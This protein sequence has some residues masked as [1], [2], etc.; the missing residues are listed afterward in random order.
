M[1]RLAAHLNFSHARDPDDV[2]QVVYSVH[3]DTMPA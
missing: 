2:R 3:L 1:R